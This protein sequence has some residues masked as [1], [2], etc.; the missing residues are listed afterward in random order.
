MRGRAEQP[1]C[2]FVWHTPAHT[3]AC[4]N[5]KIKAPESPGR[6]EAARKAGLLA[7]RKDL[8]KL[9]LMIPAPSRVGSALRAPVIEKYRRGRMR[10]R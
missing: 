5:K 8:I 2:T 3:T 9:A 10:V 1:G 7:D 4:L 6:G